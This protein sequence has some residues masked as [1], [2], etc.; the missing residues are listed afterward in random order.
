MNRVKRTSKARAIGR[1]AKKFY[2][3][4]V[5]NLSHPGECPKT[6]ILPIGF[7]SLVKL[8]W[9]EFFWWGFRRGRGLLFDL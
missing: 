6:G 5:A 9:R 3:L 7:P 4:P 8:P 2:D 1:F